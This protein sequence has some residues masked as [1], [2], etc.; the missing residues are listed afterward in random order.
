MPAGLVQDEDGVDGGLELLGEGCQ[1]QAHRLSVGLGQGKGEGLVG[2]WSAGGEQVEAL[3]ALVGKAGW[4]NAPLVPASAGGG[5][6][7][8][9]AAL[10]R[11]PAR[12]MAGPALL[13]DPGLIL[14]PQ[15][16]PLVRMGAC[17]GGE[18]RPKLL[19]R[20]RPWRPPCFAGAGA[21]SSAGTGQAAGAGSSC[22][23]CCS[24]RRRPSRHRR[25][26]PPP[27]RRSPRPA[28][29]R[30]HAAPIDRQETADPISEGDAGRSRRRALSAACC[31][32]VRPA[33]RPGFGRSCSPSGPSAL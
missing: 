25:R 16:Q 29:D 7:I 2:S 22:P 33:G 32:G 8:S 27:A 1:E 30:D 20:T 19:F 4:P 14:A 23:R 26:G 11:R 15:L 3:E 5:R 17:D 6:S 31:P 24:A 18:P 9:A 13:A 12:A 10:V 21:A 28:P